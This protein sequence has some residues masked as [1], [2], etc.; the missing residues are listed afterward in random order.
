MA[1][2]LKIHT[3]EGLYVAGSLVSGTVS[4]CGNFAYN[5]RSIHLRFSR[6]CKAKISECDFKHRVH[7]SYSISVRLG[8]KTSCSSVLT[9][10]APRIHG[11]SNSSSIIQWTPLN[12]QAT[13]RACLR[14]S[15]TRESSL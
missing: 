1:A 13:L 6:R 7:E 4:L 2:L 8:N 10:F 9:A 12:L 15:T 11:P 14:R 3:T 5:V